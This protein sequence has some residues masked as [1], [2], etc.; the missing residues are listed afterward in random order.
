MVNLL[1]SIYHINFKFIISYLTYM[2]ARN[3]EVRNK[4]NDQRK[5]KKEGKET[6]ER[7]LKDYIS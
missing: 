4:N 7:T 2:L 6:R 1:S 3:V 5:R